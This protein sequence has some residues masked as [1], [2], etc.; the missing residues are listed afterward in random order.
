MQDHNVLFAP[1]LLV[2]ELRIV[3]KY[4]IRIWQPSIALQ[5]LVQLESDILVQ[6]KDVVVLSAI[7]Q[8]FD[9]LRKRKVQS[10][11]HLEQ[12]QIRNT[13]L[14]AP[15]PPRSLLLSVVPSTVVA[16]RDLKHLQELGQTICAKVGSALLGFVLLILVEGRGGD[17]MVRVVHFVVEVQRGCA[18]LVELS[19]S[20][21]VFESLQAFRIP[22][23]TESGSEEAQ[24]DR[25]LTDVVSCTTILD[26]CCGVDLTSFLRA[27][28]LSGRKANSKYRHSKVRSTD[29][30]S[31]LAQEKLGEFWNLVD[32][33]V[34]GLGGFEAEA[35]ELGSTWD[36]GPVEERVF[37]RGRHSDIWMFRQ[38]LAPL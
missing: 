8:I 14:A 17:G 19:N 32:L 13:R 10:V 27:R 29:S 31:V 37:Q 38:G 36:P 3:P 25:R 35:Y 1:T 5:V 26:V 21:I 2:V 7:L 20:H 23:Q 28:V 18:K 4:T 33:L 24:Y 6:V 34:L 11:E 22:E 9:T 12:G 15:Q 30:S 16:Q